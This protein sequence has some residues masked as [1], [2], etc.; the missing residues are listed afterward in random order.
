LPGVDRLPVGG[1]A[2][3]EAGSLWLAGAGVMRLAR[4]S[5]TTYTTQDGLKS[6]S[7]GSVFEDRGG[8]LI[9]VTG[10]PRF[11]YLHIFDG[12][13]FSSIVPRVPRQITHF[14]WGS[15]QIHFQDHTGAWWVATDQGLCRYPR[16]TISE[17][18]RRPCPS[19]SS[20]SA[21]V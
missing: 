2:E 5:F 4:G 11:R 7:V 1:L 8:H 10:D 18:W 14:T 19:G 17:D 20:R 3:D 15:G 6:N 12:E 16:S 21:M 13:R 9:A